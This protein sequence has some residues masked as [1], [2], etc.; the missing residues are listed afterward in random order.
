[1]DGNDYSQMR[2]TN[3][4]ADVSNQSFTSL[5]FYTP[6]FTEKSSELFCFS[7]V[8]MLMILINAKNAYKLNDKK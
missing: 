4:M 5:C 3:A 2:K 1:M 8:L 6:P 7:T